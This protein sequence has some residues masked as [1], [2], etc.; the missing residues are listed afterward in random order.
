LDGEGKAEVMGRGL[1]EESFEKKPTQSHQAIQ[2]AS[3]VASPNDF[4]TDACVQM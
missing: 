2:L 4:L 1:V 3:A